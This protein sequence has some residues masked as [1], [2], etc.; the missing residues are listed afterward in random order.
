MKGQ[1]RAFSLFLLFYHLIFAVIAWKYYVDHG[2]DA[3]RYWQLSKDWGSYLNV[4]TDVIKFINYPFTSILHLHFWCGFLLYSLIGFYAIYELYRFALSYI[5]PSSILSS[6]LLMFVFLLPNLHFWTSV[7]GKEPLVFLAITWIII[8]YSEKK[9]TTFKFLFGA[10]LLILIRPHVALFLLIS[11]AV[12]MIFN[13][14]KSFPQKMIFA[15]AALAMSVGLYF[16]TIKL[17][18]RNPFNIEYILKSNEWS[19]L[20]FKRA[21]SYV[22]MIHYNV[23]ERVFALN[24]RPLFLDSKTVFDF[25]LSAENFIVLILFF[26]AIVIYIIY[27][28]KIKLD[29]FAQVALL[30]FLVSS[31]F[32]IQRYSCLGI[33]VRTK[34]MYMPFL[35]ITALQI[36]GQVKRQNRSL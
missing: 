14:K 8:S 26:A 22:P 16:M 24:F 33:F 9:Y 7:I 11:I 19:L 34:M 6:T 23:F 25:V 3:Q 12:T 27:Y 4:G 18:E 13:D 29:T 36:I 15:V 20:A 5:K 28:R 35:L 2:G 32:F 30:F 17:L 21:G 10:I 31:L 1:E